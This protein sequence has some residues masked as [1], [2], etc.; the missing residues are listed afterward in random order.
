MKDKTLI[1]VSSISGFLSVA[2]GAFGVHFLREN[3]S[4]EM[5]IIWERAVFYQF[6]HT[7]AIFTIALSNQQKLFKSAYAFL[8]GIVLFSFS[9]YLYSAT[10][11]KFFAMIT[12]L[13]GLGFL[14]GWLLLLISILKKNG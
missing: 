14:T 8:L 9:L 6:I 2:F 1:A 11:I 5:L 7:V 4:P 12:P 10:G 3:I 13:G